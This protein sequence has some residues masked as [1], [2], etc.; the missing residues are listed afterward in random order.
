MTVLDALD[1]ADD[2]ELNLA[3]HHWDPDPRLD[4]TEGDAADD[5][6]SLAGFGSQAQCRYFVDCELD[7]AEAGIADLDGLEEQF[8]RCA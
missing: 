7:P 2:L 5:E 3:G 1:G 4:D 8:G 6:P